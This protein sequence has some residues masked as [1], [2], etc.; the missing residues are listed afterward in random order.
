M[1]LSSEIRLK[2][3]KESWLDIQSKREVISKL[4][5]EK[6][7][8]QEKLRSLSQKI[9]ELF[10]ELNRELDEYNKRMV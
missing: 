2:L 7:K 6:Q 5:R 4:Q 1:A 9:P 10:N 3:L 8:A